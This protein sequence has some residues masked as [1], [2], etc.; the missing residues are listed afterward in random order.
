MAKLISGMV[1]QSEASVPEGNVEPVGARPLGVELLRQQEVAVAVPA[2]QQGP[3]VVI[4]E[5]H[6]TQ[7][8]LDHE[9]FFNLEVGGQVQLSKTIVGMRLVKCWQEAGN[10]LRRGRQE[11]KKSLATGWQEVGNMPP[12]GRQE[13]SQ[14]IGRCW[15]E[16]GEGWQVDVN[17][18]ASYWQEARKKLSRG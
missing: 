1:W 3:Q 18:L 6:H 17:R 16:A 2:P 10:R 9:V 7:F 12:R 5:K 8:S 4:S 15:K 13:A 11:V 14:R